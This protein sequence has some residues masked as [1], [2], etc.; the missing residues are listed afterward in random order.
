MLDDNFI[1]P[2]D[3]FFFSSLV[4]RRKNNRKTFIILSWMLL[5]SIPSIINHIINDIL[6]NTTI[7]NFMSTIH[8]TSGYFQIEIKIQDAA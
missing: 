4:L 5:P 7:N 1:F 8:L 2:I 3:N 6:P